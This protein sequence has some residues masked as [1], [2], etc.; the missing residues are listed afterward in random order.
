MSFHSAAVPQTPGF[1]T[2][3]QIS[4]FRSR[5]STLTNRIWEFYFF[6]MIWEEQLVGLE[7][8]QAGS[9]DYMEPK[10]TKI[11]S[12]F[13]VWKSNG[14]CKL[15]FLCVQPSFQNCLIRW[16]HRLQSW[17]DLSSIIHKL[18]GNQKEVFSQFLQKI[19]AS[20][21]L[22]KKGHTIVRDWRAVTT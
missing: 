12:T 4:W 16:E 20:A 6:R 8:A 19:F 10:M 17:Y 18:T 3:S 2:I 13:P 22:L 7:W 15:C 14:S 1:L 11:K 21:Q 5:V 9:V